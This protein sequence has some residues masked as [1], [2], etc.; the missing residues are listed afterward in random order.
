MVKR[1]YDYCLARP[2]FKGNADVDIISVRKTALNFAIDNGE[3]IT[4]VMETVPAVY[5]MIKGRR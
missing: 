2:Y 4:E 1:I 3:D 5:Q